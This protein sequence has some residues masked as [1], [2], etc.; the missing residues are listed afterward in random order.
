MPCVDLISAAEFGI[1]FFL[2]VEKKI[3]IFFSESTAAKIGI[4]IK[5]FLLI[6][7]FPFSHI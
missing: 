7:F 4:K 1:Y 6:F 3:L 5:I 2:F